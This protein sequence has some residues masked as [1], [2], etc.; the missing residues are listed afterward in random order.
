MYIELTG[1][2]P[3]EPGDFPEPI[4]QPALDEGPHLSYA[5]QWFLFSAIVVVGWVLAV[6]TGVVT[7]AHEAAV[8][9]GRG[10]P[11]HGDAQ[12]VRTRLVAQPVRRRRARR[13]RVLRG[14]P[15]AR[16]ERLGLLAPFR[17]RLVE[18]PLGL[19]L[20][21][22]IEDPDFDLDFHVRHHA[23]PP[24]G[25]PQQLSDV[26][27]PHPRPAARSVAAAVGAV[28]HRRRRRRTAGGDVH[29]GPPRRHRRRVG[30]DDARR[31]PRR[32]PRCG[33]TGPSRCRGIPRHVPSDRQLLE[34]TLLEYLRR[35][36]KFVRLSVRTLRELAAATRNGGLRVMA[37][38]I[39]QPIP[40][41]VGDFMRRR[42]RGTDHEVDNPPALPPTAAPR[43]PWNASIGPHRRFAYTTVPL[44]DAKSV[45]RAVGCT[46]NDVV[47]AL[48]SGHAAPL[49]R[50]STTACP[51]S[52]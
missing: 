32:R 37:D 29:Q 8:R 18:V 38:L 6:T 48:C 5:V 26:D 16:R 35:P 1:S 44:D 9:D 42:L 11:Q 40:G 36:E 7:F 12:H 47:M 34:R 21:Y 39:A 49:P 23:V 45:R 14:H 19:D 3:A 15:A 33:S 22:W 30:S 20:P 43:T 27:Q 10:V 25:T 17:R 4:A 52:R 46:F 13:R 51:T 2:D 28:R 50:R 31:P 41:P 24:P